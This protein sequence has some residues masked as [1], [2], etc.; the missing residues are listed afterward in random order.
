MN[1]LVQQQPA[2]VHA[3]GGRFVPGRPSVVMIHGA[4]NDHRVFV[5]LATALSGQLSASGGNAGWN[6]LAVDLPGHGGTFAGPK[7][8]IEDMADWVINLLDNGNIPRAILIGHSMGSLVALDCARRHAGRVEKLVLIGTAAPMP[9]ADKVLTTARDDVNTAYDML[10]RASFF[11]EKNADGSFP[12]PSEAMARYRQSL[13]ENQPEVLALDMQACHQYA[14]TASQLAEVHAATLVV[15][16]QA[17]RMTTAAA[18]EA[19]AAALP[20]AQ[21]A[22]IP[23]AGHSMLLEAPEAVAAAVK[24]FLVEVGK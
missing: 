13:S 1:F 15:I 24:G 19:V 8:T 6:I 17:D 18:G 22:V 3:A 4:A 10:T 12:P 7:S 11:V 5:A 2:F 20:S 16:G 23:R 14:I 9:V 21:S